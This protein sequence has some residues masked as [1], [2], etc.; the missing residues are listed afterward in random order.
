M[1]LMRKDCQLRISWLT[2]SVFEALRL[3]RECD[4]W[5]SALQKRKLVSV[6]MFMWVAEGMEYLQAYLHFTPG[7]IKFIHKRQIKLETTQSRC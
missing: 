5:N 2:W 7:M 4:E 1:N 6:L 3:L